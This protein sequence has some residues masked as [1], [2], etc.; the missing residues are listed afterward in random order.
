MSNSKS[1]RV[2]ESLRKM[3]V[4]I[5][6]ALYLELRNR[7]TDKVLIEN[8]QDRCDMI[9]NQLKNRQ[10]KLGEVTRERQAANGMENEVDEEIMQKQMEDEKVVE[11]SWAG[12]SMTT[13]MFKDIVKRL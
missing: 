7:K 6:I 9:I 3:E 13:K 1:V 4:L 2:L 5:I 11:T 10:K 8:V 12:T